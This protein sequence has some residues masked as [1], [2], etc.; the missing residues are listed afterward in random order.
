MATTFFAFCVEE[1]STEANRPPILLHH[2]RKVP[3]MRIS[4]FILAAN[5]MRA[6]SMCCKEMRDAWYQARLVMQ[7]YRAG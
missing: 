1:S 5:L 3:V 4:C 6:Q 2:V 7:K